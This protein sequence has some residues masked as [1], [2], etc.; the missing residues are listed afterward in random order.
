MKTTINPATISLTIGESFHI[1]S[2]DQAK[3]LIALLQKEVTAL[4]GSPQTEKPY[5]DEYKDLCER[6]RKSDWPWVGPI[7]PRQPLNPIPPILPSP[8][9]KPIEIWCQL[10]SSIK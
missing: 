6:P 9:Y 1:L 4:E 3:E 2:L 5:I 10:N 7:Y 8:P